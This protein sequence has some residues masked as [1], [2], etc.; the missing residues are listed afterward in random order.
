[1]IVPSRTLASSPAAETPVPAQLS[2]SSLSAESTDVP[3]DLRRVAI[4]PNQWYPLAWSREVKSGKAIGVHFG[5]VPI[6]LFRGESGQV[7]ALFDRCAH[8]QVPLHAGVVEG[9]TLKCGY[10]GWT[11]DRAGHCVDIPYL[12]R[13]RRPNGVRAY[14]C[15]EVAGLI[16][17]HCADTVL[18]QMPQPGA[19]AQSCPSAVT[20]AAKPGASPA[21]AIPIRDLRTGSATPAASAEAWEEDGAVNPANRVTPPKTVNGRTASEPAAAPVSAEQEAQFVALQAALAHGSNPEYK[22]R[23]FGETVRCHYSFMHENLMDMNHQFLHRKQMGQM[24]ARVVDRRAGSDWVEVD[25]TFAR[26]GGKQPIGEALVFGERRK[27][28]QATGK[29]AANDD[30]SPTAD[31]KT[32]GAADQHK[33]VMTIR[34]QYPYQ[35]LCIHKSDGAKVMDLWIN[36]VPVDAEQKT[37]RTFGLLS[38]KRPKPGFLLD[39]AWPLLVWFTDRIFTEDRWIV[40][41]EQAAYDKQGGDMNNEYFPVIVA[42]RELLRR[43]GAPVPL[44][45]TTPVGGSAFAAAA[46]AGGPAASATVPA[47]PASR[48]A[49]TLASSASPVPE[50]QVPAA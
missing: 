21:V 47:M 25:Y 40:E 27:T 6:V 38:I 22:T 4:D 16:L 28:D 45:A 48:D 14:P 31:A 44:P 2:D 12:G 36:Y 37:N 17:V 3:R 29:P 42:L 35:T 10:H 26:I 34:T 23:R 5:G 30:A 19:A 43:T 18:A 49:F 7:H 46:V 9:D 11:Y 1:M 13:E 50:P 15:R 8:R 32:K 39:I 20:G 41:A 33:D 24:R